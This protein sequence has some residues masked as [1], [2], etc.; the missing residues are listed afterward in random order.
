MFPSLRNLQWRQAAHVDDLSPM[1]FSPSLRSIAIS[2]VQSGAGVFEDTFAIS[3]YH[4]HVTVLTFRLLDLHGPIIS[5][6]FPTLLAAGTFA[7]SP[8]YQ[9]W[10]Y[11]SPYGRNPASP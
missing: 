10:R 8:Y 9:Q 6:T 5:A 7:P 11:T 4:V 1:L 3:H 2:L